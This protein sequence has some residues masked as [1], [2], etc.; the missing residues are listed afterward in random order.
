MVRMAF[1]VVIELSALPLLGCRA[2]E[3]VRRPEVNVGILP[4]EA[5]ES[6]LQTWLTGRAR[7]S[8]PTRVAVVRMRTSNPYGYEYGDRS[9]HIDTVQQKEADAWRS[10]GGLKDDRGRA[11]VDG[12]TFVSPLLGQDE[13]TLDTL[14]QAAARLHSPLLLV[15][16]IHDASED[17]YNDSSLLYWTIVGM[18][19][20]PGNVVGYY[21]AGQALLIDTASGQIVSVAAAESKHEEA[22]TAAAFDI[23]KN[24]IARGAQTETLANLVQDVRARLVEAAR[25]P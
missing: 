20:V 1:L 16:M 5:S 10:L 21:S 13:T 19:A 24:R 17:G 23:A 18:W 3:G 9:P 8:F 22:V 14:R 6:E 7:P 25:L 4:K 2:Y 11:L 12:V 15:Y